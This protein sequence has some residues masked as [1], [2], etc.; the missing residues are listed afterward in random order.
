MSEIATKPA[1]G[2]RKVRITDRRPGGRSYLVDDG[3]TC[4]PE[5]EALVADYREGAPARLR[6]DGRVVLMPMSFY[7]YPRALLRTGLLRWPKLL[8]C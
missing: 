7:A 2:A 6:P 5:L 8:K 1:T 3:L 4:M